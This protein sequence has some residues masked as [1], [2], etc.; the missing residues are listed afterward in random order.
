SGK[1]STAVTVTV[2]GSSQGQPV[3]LYTDKPAARTLVGNGVLDA[4]LHA[5]FN[6]LL[7]EGRQTL[8]AEVTDAA[9][10]FNDP[11][12]NNEPAIAVAVDLTAGSVSLPA[13]AT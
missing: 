4:V 8:T 13:S 11:S 1:L 3:T 5:S 12:V 9:G 10:N 6:A 7:A 2:S